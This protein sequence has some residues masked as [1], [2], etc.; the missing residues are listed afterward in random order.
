MEELIRL[1]KENNQLLKDNNRML[2]EIITVI[3]V[4]LANHNQENDKDF[5]Q[6]ILANLI[7]SRIT[8]R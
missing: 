7:S 3:N 8:G 1:A 4:W 5:C 6:N 2:R